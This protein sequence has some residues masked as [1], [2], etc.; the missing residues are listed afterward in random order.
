MT[1]TEMRAAASQLMQVVGDALVQQPDELP[2]RHRHTVS[3]LDARR[4]RN[5]RSHQLVDDD[6]TGMAA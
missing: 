3:D 4:S 1:G 5:N 2:R 6:F